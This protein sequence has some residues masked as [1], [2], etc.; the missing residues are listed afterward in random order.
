MNKAPENVESN[1]DDNVLYQVDNMIIED[2]K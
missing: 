1:F 2:T